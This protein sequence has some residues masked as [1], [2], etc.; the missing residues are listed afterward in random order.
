MTLTV[1]FTS[2]PMFSFNFKFEMYF[3]KLFQVPSC[4]I[5]LAISRTWRPRY[6]YLVILVNKDSSFKLMHC[7]IYLFKKEQQSK[8]PQRFE[9][10]AGINKTNVLHRT[11]LIYFTVMKKTP[12]KSI[13]T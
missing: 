11:V 9:Y 4:L 12:V 3:P 5:F 6:I 1:V 2:I 8:D 10:Y 7:V 13:G